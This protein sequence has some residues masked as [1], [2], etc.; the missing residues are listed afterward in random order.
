M[1][2]ILKRVWIETCFFIYRLDQVFANFV[3]ML[4]M[5]LDE[6][7]LPFFAFFGSLGFNS[8]A[9]HMVCPDFLTR[10]RPYFYAFHY[11]FG[12]DHHDL[13]ARLG[14]STTRGQVGERFVASV[15]AR[16]QLGE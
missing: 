11:G 8:F 13:V 15:F 7:F 14:G 1:E 12:V 5:H 16:L 3:G 9:S 2:L 4:L 10:N 6:H